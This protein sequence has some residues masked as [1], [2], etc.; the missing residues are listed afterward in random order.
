MSKCLD[1]IGAVNLEFLFW[2]YG[3]S[4]AILTS[5]A[6]V[7]DQCLHANLS[8][9]IPFQTDSAPCFCLGSVNLMYVVPL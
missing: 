5:F 1:V 7:R 3:H 6:V 2:I 8:Y 4:V 9:S